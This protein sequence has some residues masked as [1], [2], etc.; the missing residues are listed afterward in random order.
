M[1][2]VS[3]WIIVDAADWHVELL[4]DDL[5]HR[6]GDPGAELDLAGIDR[7]VAGGVDGEEAIDFGRAPPACGARLA[8]ALPTTGR[9]VKS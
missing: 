8:P 9:P 4:G 7:D 5:A 2:K 1:S 6:R 3:P